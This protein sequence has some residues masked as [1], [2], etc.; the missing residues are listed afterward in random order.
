[1]K[2]PIKVC[3]PFVGNNVGG[4]HVSALMLA[5]NLDRDTAEPVVVLHEEGPLADYVRQ[6][7]LDYELIRIHEY[8]KP[9]YWRLHNVIALAAQTLRIA[10]FLRRAKV[11]VV[12]SND[13][14]I[15]FGW[16]LASRL[17]GAQL[18]WHQR[19][20]TFGRKRTKLAFALLSRTV[21]CI[22]R[23]TEST[24]PR[25]LDPL[26]RVVA[27]P[28]DTDYA[29]LDRQAAKASILARLKLEEGTT[30][31]GFFG[32]LSQQKRPEVFVE[33][34]AQL[35]ETSRGPVAFLL[36]GA[37]RGDA[38]AELTQLARSLGIEDRVHFMGFQAPIEPWMAG[39]D[40]MMAPGVGDGLGRS[41]VEAMICGTPVVAADSGGHREVISDGLTGRLVAA[42]N[43]GA[44]AEAMEA[45]LQNPDSANDM[46]DRA[47]R[48]ASERYSVRTHVSEMMAIYR[49]ALGL[50]AKGGARAMDPDCRRHSRQDTL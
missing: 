15:Q 13:I 49:D 36:F 22:S 14:R 5:S 17:A 4:S 48:E 18:I 27:N 24:L 11:D 21:V 7:G 35:S 28:F 2:R 3:F 12:H 33:A 23:Y 39:C 37:E 44:F 29:R 42:D 40:L 30:L 25:R 45:L 38:V 6:Q 20:G 10:A 16:T 43:P 41:L 47:Q 8:F 34:A 31:V 19:T 46:A 32:N 9:P 26:I 1:M 50:P